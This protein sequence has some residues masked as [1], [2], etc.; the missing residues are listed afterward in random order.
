VRFAGA[1]VFALALLLYAA[2]MPLGLAQWDTGEMQTVPYILGIAHP[3]GFPLYVLIGWLWSHALPLGDVASRLTGLSAVCG[4][5]A[6]Y[7][8]YRAAREL[9]APPAAGLLAGALFALAPLVVRHVT[10]A[11]VEPLLVLCVGLAVVAGLRFARRGSP[12]TPATS[13][14]GGRSWPSRRGRRAPAWRCWG[15]RCW[16]S[17]GPRWAWDWR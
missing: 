13:S 6:A 14:A 7:L 5:A 9:D 10:R 12:P 3:P 8:A 17:A 15:W 2:L 4:A 11:G 16:S 1:G